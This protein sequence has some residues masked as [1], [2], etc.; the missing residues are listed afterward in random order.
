M[1]AFHQRLVRSLLSE[2][3]AIS[4]TY[5]KVQRKTYGIRGGPKS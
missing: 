2:K 3:E 4:I 1:W 5:G